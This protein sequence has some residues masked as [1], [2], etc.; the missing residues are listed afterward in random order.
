MCCS[1]AC[2]TAGPHCRASLQGL[3]AGSHCR[4]SV[5]G[6]ETK[7]MLKMGD[8]KHYF[9]LKLDC[10]VVFLT[11]VLS[12]K[13]A[14]HNNSKQHNP[15]TMSHFNFQIIHVCSLEETI[16]ILLKNDFALFMSLWA[17]ERQSQS[18]YPIYHD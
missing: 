3:I 12:S 14:S 1:S 10:F 17:I 7:M 6:L 2:T 8:Q 18:N 16:F 9:N 15:S 5:Q 4:V 11:S 13:H